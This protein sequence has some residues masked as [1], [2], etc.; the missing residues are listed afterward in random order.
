MKRSHFKYFFETYF[1][2]PFEKLDIWTASD[3]VHQEISSSYDCSMSEVDCFFMFTKMLNQKEIQH[4]GF[5]RVKDSDFYMPFFTYCSKER[6]VCHVELSFNYDIHNSVFDCKHIP[7][8]KEK[9]AEFYGLIMDNLQPNIKKILND[10][11]IF[12][13]TESFKKSF[14]YFDFDMSCYTIEVTNRGRNFNEY[15][16]IKWKIGDLFNGIRVIDPTITCHYHL[17]YVVDKKVD[18]LM[19]TDISNFICGLNFNFNKEELLRQSFSGMTGFVDFDYT[20]IDELSSLVKE[21]RQ[22]E[23]MYAIK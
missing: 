20:T 16:Q 23:S 22:V 15:F 7:L 8:K 19:M 14:I 10:S 11:N 1:N 18:K 5:Y 2:Y 4:Y 9:T 6:I 13:L 3:A 21:Y 12:T 17:Q